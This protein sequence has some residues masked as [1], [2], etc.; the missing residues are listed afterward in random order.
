[1]KRRS[2]SNFDRKA[3]ACRDGLKCS[4]ACR[5]YERRVKWAQ[6]STSNLIAELEKRRPCGKCVPGYTESGCGAPER[7]FSC[8]WLEFGNDN[9][10]EAK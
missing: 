5:D 6:L 9:F 1:M 7:C 2:C 10:K 8:M 4:D 3:K